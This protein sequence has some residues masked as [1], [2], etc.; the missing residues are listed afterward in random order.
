MSNACKYAY[1]ADAAGEIRVEFGRADEG[2]FCLQVEDDG[3]GLSPG[4]DP[5]GTGLGARLITAMA[6]SL[7]STVDYDSAHRGVRA[8][9][10]A[11]I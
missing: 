3:C 4:A 11:A 8:T 9:L 10:L 1:P 2:H 6:R 5:R 7:S